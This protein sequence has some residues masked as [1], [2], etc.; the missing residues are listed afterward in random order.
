MML[1]PTEFVMLLIIVAVAFLVNGCSTSDRYMIQDC[2]KCEAD[3]YCYTD[4][5]IMHN[6]WC[7]K[8]LQGWDINESLLMNDSS[9]IFINDSYICITKEEYNNLTG[10]GTLV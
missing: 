7:V 10:N 1:S 6:K 3:E 9:R 5:S 4:E 8:Q 2:D